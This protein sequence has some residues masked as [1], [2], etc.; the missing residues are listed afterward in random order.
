MKSRFVI[1]G[2]PGYISAGYFCDENIMLWKVKPV[3]S[4]VAVF[5]VI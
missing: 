1:I 2:C 4:A 5:S 3:Y